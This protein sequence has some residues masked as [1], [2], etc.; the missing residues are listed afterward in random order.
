MVNRSPGIYYN[1]KSYIFRT[2]RFPFI[3]SHLFKRTLKNIV[4]K[5]FKFSKPLPENEVKEKKSDRR[6]RISY[7]SL[8]LIEKPMLPKEPKTKQP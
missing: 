1:C 8:M 5:E 2:S 4:S 7:T 3:T 6:N